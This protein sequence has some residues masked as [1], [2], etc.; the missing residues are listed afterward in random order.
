MY[1]YLVI[2]EEKEKVEE[3]KKKIEQIKSQYN[4]QIQN[5][6]SITFT[7]GGKLVIVGEIPE[8]MLN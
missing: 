1:L 5:D 6:K 4:P 2:R 3:Q 7:Q 8:M